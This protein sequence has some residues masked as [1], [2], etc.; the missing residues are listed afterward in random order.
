MIVRWP[1][2]LDDR[3]ISPRDVF[4]N[5]LEALDAIRTR[6]EVY[7]NL[8]GNKSGDWQI[9]IQAPEIAN[10]EAAEEH[11]K[12]MIEKVKAEEMGLYNTVSVVL[13]DQEGME[14]IF[15][16]TDAWWPKTDRVV[17]RLLP[18]EMMDPPGSF[19]GE[20]LHPVQLSKIQRSFQLALEAV[21]HRKGAYDLAIRLGCLS[22]RSKQFKDADIGKKHKKEAFLRSIHGSLELGIERW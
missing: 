2:E 15:K 16:R 3:D 22:L 21:R 7:I 19:R 5:K 8:L 6:D 12:N 18:N 11:L 9:E 1:T 17:P 14:V 13:D 20:G 10:L 4:S